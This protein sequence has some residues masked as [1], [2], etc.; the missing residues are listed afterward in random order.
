MGR[1]KGPNH[2]RKHRRTFY[3]HWTAPV[4]YQIF[5]L[6]RYR[7][8]QWNTQNKITL[9]NIQTKTAQRNILKGIGPGVLM[10][11]DETHQPRPHPLLPHCLHKVH[12]YHWKVQNHC[13]SNHRLQP[14]R[15]LL[16]T[17]I[18]GRRKKEMTTRTTNF[19]YYTVH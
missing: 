16:R 3:S 8:T 1:P 18:L 2:T 15:L 10:A 7:K 6:Y 5:P 13:R 19:S 12:C 4:T 17:W 11:N 9:R 14:L